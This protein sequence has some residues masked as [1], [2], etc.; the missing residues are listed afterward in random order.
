[1]KPILHNFIHLTLCCVVSLRLWHTDWR[2][3]EVVSDAVCALCLST[4]HQQQSTSTAMHVRK[5]WRIKLNEQWEGK[6]GKSR[7]CEQASATIKHSVVKT[8]TMTTEACLWGTCRVVC[9]RL[10]ATNYNGD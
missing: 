4:D 2:G 3:S 10:P 7:W 6:A 1:M 5:K 9:S 8:S